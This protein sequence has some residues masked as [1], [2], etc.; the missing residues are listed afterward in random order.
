MRGQ[1]IRLVANKM[2]VDGQ[3]EVARMIEKSAVEEL[4]KAVERL[5]HDGTS[6][7]VNP[8]ERVTTLM[9]ALC[10]QKH[11]LLQCLGDAFVKLPRAGKHV[12]IQRAKEVAGHIG[13][14]SK[15]LI[16]LIR[17]ELL[18][19]QDV[20][21]VEGRKTDNAEDLAASLLLTI[22]K[23]H[24][25]EDKEIVMAGMRRFELC[26]DAQFIVAVLGGVARE[27]VVKFLA[28][29]IECAAI[30]SKKLKKEAQDAPASKG[31]LQK[32]GSDEKEADQKGSS[33][34]DVIS[35]VVDGRFP[36][37]GAADLLMELHKLPAGAAVSAAIRACFEYKAV[38]KQEAIAQAIQQMIGLTQV[39][40]MFMRTVMLARL[41]HPDLEKYLTETVMQRLIKK[42]VWLSPVL[43][44]GFLRYCSDIR[45]TP[46]VKLLFSLP[47]KQLEDAL[48]KKDRLRMMFQALMANQKHWRKLGTAHRKVIVASLKK[49]P[50]GSK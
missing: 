49:R 33:L 46:A 37:M 5:C 50:S 48:D 8:L 2:F 15:P 31:D 18:P 3:N 42:R 36:V 45:E 16:A 25:T 34:Q 7:D 39:P 40:D 1:T 32:D 43:W 4:S 17:G 12:I 22:V 23:K 44:D 11:Q 27:D 9:A 10:G 13:V 6:V 38:F 14:R 24:G 30:S 26:G 28:P 41:L 47:V 20:K 19:L 21:C 35:K 29:I